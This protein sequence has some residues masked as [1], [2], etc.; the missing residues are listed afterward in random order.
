MKAFVPHFAIAV[1]LEPKETNMLFKQTAKIKNV[2]SYRIL[3]LPTYMHK[4]KAQPCSLFTGKYGKATCRGCTSVSRQNNVLHVPTG[5]SDKTTVGHLGVPTK[6]FCLLHMESSKTS[7][8]Q[9]VVDKL[10]CVSW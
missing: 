3:L 8:G 9:W 1:T 10:N 2:L 7:I 5:L 6:M 4:H